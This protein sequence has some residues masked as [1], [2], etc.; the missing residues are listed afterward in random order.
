MSGWLKLHRK[1]LENPIMQ[2]PNYLAVFIYLLTNAN[3]EPKD[4]IINNEKT[5]IP[6]GSFIGSQRKISELLKISLGSVNKI[7]NYLKDERTIEIKPTNKF[8]Y[9]SITNWEN[10]QSDEHKNEHKMN[11]TRTQNEHSVKQIKNIK[12]IKKER[13]ILLE[14]FL[15]AELLKENETPSPEKIV[16]ESLAVE[17]DKRN[18]VDNKALWAKY[19]NFYQYWT[20]KGDKKPTDPYKINWIKTWINYIERK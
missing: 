6:V 4:I 15:I 2:K 10:Y 20:G 7:L 3:Y 8:C 17:W 12:N 13:N 5:T 18:G 9:F 14:D 11:T 1:I 16:P 19:S